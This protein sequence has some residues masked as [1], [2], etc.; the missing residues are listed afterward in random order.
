MIDK[1]L[2]EQTTSHQ[3]GTTPRDTTPVKDIFD[4]AGLLDLLTGDKELA[5]KIFNEF[6]K[7]VPRKYTALKDALEKEDAVSVQRLA[8][9]LNG[10]SANIGALALQDL[11]SQIEFASKSGNLHK[12]G[13]LIPKI[14]E[15]F[16][17]LRKLD[18][19]DIFGI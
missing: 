19:K 5:I 14:N 15:Q 7:D 6:L 9:T 1:W 10:A 2:S 18:L 4:K 12:A 13:S 16:E 11:A 8:H 3:N 17:M